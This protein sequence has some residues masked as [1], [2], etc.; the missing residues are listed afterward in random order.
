M[1]VRRACSLLFATCWLIPPAVWAAAPLLTETPTPADFALAAGGR[2]APLYVETRDDKAIVR[3]AGDFSADLERV[4][5]VKPAE[6][7]SGAT[8]PT[9]V[10]IVGA[11]GHSPLI[12]A[13]AAAGKLDT[14]GITGAWESYV[15]QTVA[16]PAPGVSRALV[17][18]GSDRRGTIYGL[19]A[20]SEASGVSPWYWWA[21]VPVKKHTSLAV[22]AGAHKQGPPSVK[23][24][25]IFINDE[26][27]GMEPWAAKTF[28][29]DRGNIGPKTYARICELLLR[30]H[31]NTLWPAMHEVS[32]AFN[33]VPENRVVADTYGIVMGSSHCE[34]MLRNN[35]GEWPKDNTAGFNFITNPAGVTSYWEQRVKENAAFEN[36]YTIGMRGIHDGPMQGPKG[37]QQNVDTLEK[38]FPAQRA[39]LAKYVNP[40]PAKVPQ[41]FCPYKEV[42]TYYLQGLKIPS[43]VTLV[44]PDDNFGYIRYFPSAAEVAARPG[45]FGVYYHISYLGGPMSYLWL[46]TTPPALIW[47]EMSKAYDHG[48]RNLWIVNV[49]DLKP[50]EIGMEFFL[51]MAYDIN[52]WHADNLP[53]YLAER[54]ARDFGPEHARETADVLAQYYHLNFQRKPEHLQ[55]WLPGKTPVPSP[56]TATEIKERLDAFARLSAEADRLQAAQ[57]PEARD[58]F[59]EQVD[60]PARDS[61]LANQRYFYGELAAAGGADAADLAARAQAADNQMQADTRRYNEEIAGGKWRHMLSLEPADKQ[62]ASIRAAAW[63]LPTFAGVAKLAPAAAAP[64]GAPVDFKGFVQTGGVVAID[65]GHFTNN[66]VRPGAKWVAVSGLGRTGNA[67]LVVPSNTAEIDPARLTAEA[68]RLEYVVQFATAGKLTLTANLLPAHSLVLARGLRFAVGLDDQPPQVVNANVKDTSA[69]WAQSVLNETAVATAALEVATA[70]VHTLKIYMVDPGVALDKFTLSA[71]DTLP[72]YLG[73]PETR[74]GF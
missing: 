13:L 6:V 69:D 53:D 59:F 24:R 40:D 16:N 49:G 19:Y 71:G 35:V 23:Y 65:A 29:P 62:W 5:G 37:E 57:P 60:Y 44:F 64:T 10:V 45:G 1:N 33:A 50:G 54:A 12:D 36:I 31:A 72:G 63:Q 67:V 21:D 74:V 39:L 18:A 22:A 11:L 61:A 43:D 41:I 26:D 3:A 56:L 55:W 25:G 27:W 52:R 32:T 17:I 68:P 2:V 38:I 46:N 48:M 20:V 30:L 73:P 7:A 9:Q 70:G 28:E 51:Q 34:P 4:T 58:A 14:S 8:L 66:V 42:L 47:E 15:I